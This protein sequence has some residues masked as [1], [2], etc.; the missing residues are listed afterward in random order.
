MEK[1]VF[2][3]PEVEVVKFNENDILTDSP[4]TPGTGAGGGVVLPDIDF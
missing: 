1:K 3:L 2:I 4:V